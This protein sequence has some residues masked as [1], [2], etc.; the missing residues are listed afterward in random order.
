MPPVATDI[1]CVIFVRGSL[2]VPIAFPRAEVPGTMSGRGR[3]EA[4]RPKSRGEKDG[5][6]NREKQ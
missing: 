2:F 3:S 4:L 5:T 1:M 6:A